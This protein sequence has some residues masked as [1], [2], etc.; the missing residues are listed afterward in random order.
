MLLSTPEDFEKVIDSLKV[1]R[2]PQKKHEHYN[3]Y[4]YPKLVFKIDRPDIVACNQKYL[5]VKL[6]DTH[7]NLKILMDNVN[8]HF[9]NY[10]KNNFNIR[11][12]IMSGIHYQKTTEGATP[13]TD[14]S[15]KCHFPPNKL[16][17]LTHVASINA[18][19]HNIWETGDKLGYHLVVESTKHGVES[20]K[21]ASE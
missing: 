3:Y 6:N 15:I 1:I 21:Y 11:G 12:K 17:N 14:T 9:S 18:E 5:I 16:F 19:L 13:P 7:T 8:N 10:I 4:I 2:R 20:T